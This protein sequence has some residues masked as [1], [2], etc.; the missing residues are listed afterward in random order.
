MKTTSP[1]G[2]AHIGAASY[3]GAWKPQ[4]NQQFGSGAVYQ[5]YIVLSASPGVIDFGL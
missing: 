1:N 3:G 4:V 2:P 5:D